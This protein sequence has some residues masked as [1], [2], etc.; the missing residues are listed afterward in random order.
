MLL[1]E[2][3]AIAR[4]ST[5]PSHLGWWFG[6]L[7]GAYV[8]SYVVNIGFSLDLGRWPQYV[9]VASVVGLLAWGQLAHGQAWTQPLGWL[10]VAWLIY[11]FAHLGISFVLAAVLATPGC[12]M[13]AIP[14]LFTL[15]SG[16]E[17]AEHFCPG[18]LRWVDEWELKL[19]A[20]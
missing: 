12:E 8:F 1:T 9:V 10:L 13:R 15:L 7:V 18:P 6:V 11:T 3:G 17:T 4:A 2:G 5:A 19:K 20:S 14:H 16:R